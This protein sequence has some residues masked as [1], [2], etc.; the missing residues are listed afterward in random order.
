MLLHKL[1]GIVWAHFMTKQR[2]IAIV[3]DKNIHQKL[4]WLH[5]R[6]MGDNLIIPLR[7]LF[8]NVR[9]LFGDASNLQTGGFEEFIYLPTIVT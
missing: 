4:E 1:L 2:Q 7:G 6:H 3:N 5:W 8:V 9:N